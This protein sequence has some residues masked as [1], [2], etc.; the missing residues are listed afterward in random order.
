MTGRM[1]ECLEDLLQKEAPDWVLVYGDTNSTFAGALAVAK[2]HIQV[3]HVEAG[4]RSFNRHMPEEHNRILTDHLADI[5]FT[6]TDAATENLRHEGV[7]ES[8]IAQVG[9]VMFDAALFYAERA[10][11]R[12]AILAEHGLLKG[13][14]VLA[15]VH[16]AENTDDPERLRAIMAGLDA[17]AQVQPVIL[18]LH[19]RTRAALAREDIEP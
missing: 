17:A 4:L 19:P 10:A 5:L 13:N 1:L 7:P 9:D 6:P 8:R 2:L 15:T 3:A 16:R 12:S 11:E 14:Y 18:P